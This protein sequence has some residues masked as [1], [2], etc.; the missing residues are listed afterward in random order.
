M[1]VFCVGGV[2]GSGWVGGA[3]RTRDRVL[4]RG[5]I[6]TKLTTHAVFAATNNL[7]MKFDT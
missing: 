1:R 6:I 4:G 7:K 2:E 5:V 3:V